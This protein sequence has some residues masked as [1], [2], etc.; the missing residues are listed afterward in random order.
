MRKI[1][2]TIISLVLPLVCGAQ[3][4]KGSY[5]LDNSLNRHELNPAFAPRAD[6]VQLFGIGNMGF[7][8]DGNMDLRTFFYPKNGEMLTFLHP[9]ISAS[10]FDKALAKTP[11]VGAECSTTLLGFGFYTGKKSYWTFDLDLQANMD[12]ALPRDLFMF[13][14]KG[15]GTSSRSMNVG[16]INMSGY[17][18]I[19]ASLGYSRLIFE[20]LR[21]GAKARLIAPVTYYAVD[22]DK[23]TLETSSEKWSLKTEGYAHTALN[24]NLAVM[25]SE[26]I[27]LTTLISKDALAGFGYSFDLGAEYVLEKGT[28]IDGLTVSAAVT[29]LGCIHYD[30]SAV[31]S[32][33]AQGNVE[34][35]G[36]EDVENLESALFDFTEVANNGR[37]TRSTMPK[38]HI[39]AEM[40]FLK[41][42]MSVGL[43]YSARIGHSYTTNELMV[44]YNLNPCR[45]FALGLNYSILSAA[46]SIGMIMEFTPRVGPA[47]YIGCDYIATQFASVSFVPIVKM[48]PLSMR[49]SLNFGLAIHLGGKTTK[50]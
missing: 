22:I 3:A 12:A 47:F 4:L 25:N 40:P 16:K 8:V 34:W 20:G 15:T 41:N 42:L 33:V 27:D 31:S 5:F 9:S 46:N 49:C 26:D 19:Q 17:T 50:E 2:L 6:Y 24:P 23:M 38:V 1:F 11:R 18:G 45:W 35:T 32:Y 13:L 36:I 10:D 43:L 44:S 7:S 21:V 14:K 28:C 48:L 37:Y 39:G 29:D 30:E